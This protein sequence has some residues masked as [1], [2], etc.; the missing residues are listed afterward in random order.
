MTNQKKFYVRGFSEKRGARFW[1]SIFYI[2]VTVITLILWIFSLANLS[3]YYLGTY[4]LLYSIFMGLQP[5]AYLIDEETKTLRKVIA[6]GFYTTKG[7]PLSDYMG[8]ELG[9]NSKYN[10]GLRTNTGVSFIAFQEADAFCSALN[11]AIAANES[12]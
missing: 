9:Q 6:Y 11:T 2:V 12:K 8:A 10:V 3:V 4:F 1:I 5:E 7:R